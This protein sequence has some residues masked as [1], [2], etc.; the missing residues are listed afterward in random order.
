M[1][2]FSENDDCVRETK[3]VLREKIQWKWNKLKESGNTLNVGATTWVKED[4][5]SNLGLLL[6]IQG[7][8]KFYLTQQKCDE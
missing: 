4:K 3:I 8:N 1:T 7:W 6:E 2:F 5:T